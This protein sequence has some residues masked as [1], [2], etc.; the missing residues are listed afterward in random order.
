M[1]ILLLDLV[2][3]KESDPVGSD[4]VPCTVHDYNLYKEHSNHCSSFE[5][6]S[7]ECI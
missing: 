6:R 3:Q 4:P 5:L 1:S 2:G 7:V